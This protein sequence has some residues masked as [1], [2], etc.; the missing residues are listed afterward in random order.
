ML[1]K[2]RQGVI[3]LDFSVDKVSLH[4][5]NKRLGRGAAKLGDESAFDGD[6]IVAV[7]S[8]GRFCVGDQP[9]PDLLG[10]SDPDERAF[11][12]AWRILSIACET[13]GV[14]QV[15]E[16]EIVGLAGLNVNTLAVLLKDCGVALL[17]EGKGAPDA[18]AR[19]TIFYATRAEDIIDIRKRKIVEVDARLLDDPDRRGSGHIQHDASEL[20]FG[21]EGAAGDPC[22]FHGGVEKRF[23]F[24]AKR[25]VEI[26]LDFTA[27][28]HDVDV[29]E[30]GV[31]MLFNVLGADNSTDRH[32]S[33]V[34]ATHGEVG[35]RHFRRSKR[36][37]A[38]KETDRRP[39]GN[40]RSETGVREAIHLY[41]IAGTDRKAPAALDV[42]VDEDAAGSILNEH[43][44]L[45]RVVVAHGPNKVNLTIG[46]LRRW[47][48]VELSCTGDC[49]RRRRGGFGAASS[50]ER[51]QEEN[52]RQKGKRARRGDNCS[53]SGSMAGRGPPENLVP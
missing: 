53:P 27:T 25:G 31:L 33:A 35:V 13:E 43:H 11:T 10:L 41:K 42:A 24:V 28:H 37:S 51:D 39:S 6:E 23:E 45:I 20:I 17:V 30:A 9:G 47:E 50:Q 46:G 1:L 26:D 44:G 4:V 12:K 22:Q 18:H 16:V 15:T 32:Q 3:A 48:V 36:L 5:E 40:L 19:G 52:Q 14:D 7:V 38:T 49:V 29:S 8:A 34:A 2:W 21:V